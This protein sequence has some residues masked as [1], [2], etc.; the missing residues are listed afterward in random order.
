MLLTNTEMHR[1]LMMLSKYTACGGT[2]GYAI[3][4]NS[5]RLRDACQEYLNLYKVGLDKYGEIVEGPNG[6]PQRAIAYTSAHVQQFIA[7][8]EPYAHIKHE[9]EVFQVPMSEA[10]GQLT[11]QG[12][13]DLDFMLVDTDEVS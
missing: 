9:V 8:L 6:E 4:R 1:R 5:R 3:A 13:L 7:E 10:I 2:V 12:M 11:A